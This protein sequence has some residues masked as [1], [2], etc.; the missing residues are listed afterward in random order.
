MN[1]DKHEPITNR[2]AI[3]RVLGA[4]GR[5]PI[6]TCPLH[7]EDCEA[8]DGLDRYEFIGSAGWHCHACPGGCEPPTCALAEEPWR[9]SFDP[10]EG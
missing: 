5:E 4:L 10:G 2:L 7:G 9:E 3:N 6:P 1:D 8:V